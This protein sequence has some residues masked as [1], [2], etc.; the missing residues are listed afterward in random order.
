MAAYVIRLIAYVRMTDKT[1][2]FTTQIRV[3]ADTHAYLKEQAK[4]AGI[5]VGQAA[6]ALLDYARRQ[7]LTVGPLVVE[8]TV[9][10][11]EGVV[12]DDDSSLAATITREFLPSPR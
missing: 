4:T 11:R 5:S 3:R 10:Q 12:L 6:G 7:E 1:R 2:W 9:R 8:R